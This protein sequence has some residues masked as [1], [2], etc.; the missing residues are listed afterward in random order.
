[1]G[2]TLIKWIGI[3]AAVIAIASAVAIAVMPW[4]W[5][6]AYA[7][8]RASAAIGRKLTVENIDLVD[9]SLTPRIRLE[10]ARLE[11]TTW[12]D[13]PYMLVI[14][15]LAFSIDLLALLKSGIVLSDVDIKQP[16]LHLAMPRKGKPNWAFL[17]AQSANDK[18]AIPIIEH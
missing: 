16:K 15:Q 4:E 17:T 14:P 11:N 10:K 13:R 1:M 7:M 5:V 18:P 6:K 2:L 3:I 9:L 12:S 8:D